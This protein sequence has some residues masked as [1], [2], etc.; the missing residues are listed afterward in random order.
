MPGCANDHQPVVT[1]R[2]A[3]VIALTGL[4][5][6][7]IKLST[8]PGS[9]LPW[10][11]ASWIY[12]LPEN[13][14]RGARSDKS[15]TV[16]QPSSCPRS[17]A[18]ECPLPSRLDDE[19]PVDWAAIT[20]TAPPLQ[21]PICDRSD[22]IASDSLRS[23]PVTSNFIQNVVSR[24]NYDLRVVKWHIMMTVL[25]PDQPPITRSPHEI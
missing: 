6:D 7:I 23:G 4:V 15:S 16:G 5:A 18:V 14:Q 10:I 1:A 25:S 20:K 17:G 9:D 2:P 8:I 12:L 24:P 13:A 22:T 3:V 11:S 19:Q 21:F